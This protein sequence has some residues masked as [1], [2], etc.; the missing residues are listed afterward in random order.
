MRKVLVALLLFGAVFVVKAESVTQSF[1]GLNVSANLEK[2]GENWQQGPVL[3]M[4]HG[5][6]AHNRMEIMKNLQ[7]AFVERGLSSLAINLSL[8][9]SDREGMYD[10]KV[11]HTHK[12]TDAVEEIGLWLDWLKQQGVGKVVLLGHSRGGNQTARYLIE[13]DSD[14]IQG[15]VFIAPQTWSPDKSS[16]SYQKRYGKPLPPVLAQA[17]QW[18]SEGK[19]ESLIQPVDFV[20]CEGTAAT[21]AAILSYH[22]EDERMDTPGLLGQASKPLLVFSGSADTSIPDIPEKMAALGDR[23]NLRYEVIDGADHFFRDLYA[24]DLADIVQEF[25]EGL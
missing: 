11:A 4:T 24:E 13:Q 20:Y 2:A 9:L 12:H 7:K 1:K 21:A 25:V 3:L 10:C 6:L 15:A 23:E 16:K 18:V 5:T 14:L 17:E 8:G 19:G 22:T